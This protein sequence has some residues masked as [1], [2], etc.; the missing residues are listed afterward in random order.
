MS[1]K[2]KQGQL[3]ARLPR[4]ASKQ[5]DVYEAEEANDD[6]SNLRRFDAVENYEYETPSEFEDEEIDE[7]LAFTAEDE[8]QFGSI[9]G[10][11]AASDGEEAS[12][13]AEGGFEELPESDD[14]ELPTSE[15]AD[16]LDQE[17]REDIEGPAAADHES[18]GGRSADEL[19]DDEAYNA[20]IQAVQG[21]AAAATR[22]PQQ[23]RRR[24]SVATE[25]CPESEYNVPL[26]SHA[27]GEGH[28]LDIRDML[29]SLRPEQR[30][31]MGPNRKR[32]EGLSKKGKAVA[33]PLPT[34]IRQRQE[35]KAGYEDR[36]EDIAKWQPIIK[37][38]REAPTLTFTT[39]QERAAKPGSVAAL[40]ATFTPDNKMEAE[41]A[42]VLEKA[43]AT[44]SKQ[45]EQSES[46]AALKAMSA[47]EAKE[48]QNRLAKMRSL[49]LHH[50]AKARRLKA[51]KSKSFHRQA[52]R[53]AKRKAAKEAGAE[54]DEEV[55]RG[56]EEEAEFRRAQERLT[57][58][59]RNSSKWA[60]HAL[61]RG[62]HLLDSSTKSAV[63]EQLRLGQELK[64]KAERVE[65]ASSSSD[66]DEGLASSTSGSDGETAEGIRA[67]RREARAERRRKAADARTRRAATS[68]LDGSDEP[69][70]EQKGLFSLPF[71]KRAMEKRKLEAQQEAQEVLR[72]LDAEEGQEQPPSAAPSGR[73]SFT[74]AASSQAA[75]EVTDL[76]Q[77]LQHADGSDAEEDQ[78]AKHERLKAAA[79]EDAAGASSAAQAALPDS[80]PGSANLADLL[81]WDDETPDKAHVRSKPASGKG[82]KQKSKAAQ[83]DSGATKARKAQEDVQHSSVVAEPSRAEASAVGC[84]SGEAPAGRD[85]VSMDGVL[86]RVA[87]AQ[88]SRLFPAANG[89]SSHDPLQQ[90]PTAAGSAPNGSLDFI[91]APQFSGS[92]PGYAFSK[93]PQ[94][95]GYY[96]ES[97]QLRPAQP[98]LQPT[99]SAPQHKDGL[100]NGVAAQA[101]G[102]KGKRRGMANGA[103]QHDKGLPSA[104]DEGG[105]SGEEDGGLAGAMAPM[106]GAEMSQRELVAQ[107]FAGDDVEADFQQ[108]KD[109]EVAEEVPKVEEPSMLPGWGTWAGQQREPKW[110]RD[111]RVKAQKEKD[112]ALKARKDAKLKAVVVSE[113]W[114]KRAAKYGTPDVPFPFHSRAIYDQSM[115]Q[116][117]GKDYNPTSSYRDMTRPPVLKEAGS[118]IQ[119]IQFSR[120]YAEQSK[121][122]GAVSKRRKTAVVSGG[123]PAAGRR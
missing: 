18:V 108:M 15:A 90:Q 35:R 59:H 33:A 100:G 37:A 89:T 75:Q 62:A 67:D 106:K 107:A 97:S 49:L 70:G 119:P 104:V 10:G 101:K 40:A 88:R 115:R 74:A 19:E 44:S 2:R 113:R 30:S 84:L 13:D 48:R 63:N 69:D 93:G 42:A 61:R 82:R 41:I 81:G 6:E 7:D 54:G 99:T 25:A 83:G 118:I 16:P 52:N 28:E 1:K 117:I 98:S 112:A 5:T 123:V 78:D 105:S 92:K 91:Q 29:R 60:K 64:Q 114:D 14:E 120:S 57:M 103:L 32:L 11:S 34:L 102:G 24:E 76:R 38:N 43:G 77:H 21:E 121:E 85:P 27:D 109:A 71:M 20:M 36:V 47:D 23:Q 95:L 65:G 9:I 12:P 111:A 96:T 66:E 58:K 8:Q 55:M 46:A 39:G 72:E 80:L 94:G 50:E 51:I 87:A 110:M 116:P 22:A 56:M 68:M 31:R 86:A 4:K 73:M 3:G 79:A 26:D 45:V 122:R 53:A 17:S